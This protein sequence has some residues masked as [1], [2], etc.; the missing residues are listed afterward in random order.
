VRH[1]QNSRACCQDVCQGTG[2]GLSVDVEAPHG[3]GVPA[4]SNVLAIRIGGDRRQRRVAWELACSLSHLSLPS[5]GNARLGSRAEHQDGP[6]PSRPLALRALEWASHGQWLS[7]RALRIVH[8]P[9]RGLHWR[10]RG[11]APTRPVSWE[12]PGDA[13]GNAPGDAAW[14]A[15]WNGPYSWGPRVLRRPLVPWQPLGGAP[16][17]NWAQS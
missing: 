13:P 8:L 5:M 9:H 2:V 16:P 4:P 3:C 15:P 11:E 7:R 17:T 6:S 1:A 14:D 10:R 12:A